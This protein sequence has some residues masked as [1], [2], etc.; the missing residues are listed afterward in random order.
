MKKQFIDTGAVKKQHP[1]EKVAA[2]MGAERCKKNEKIFTD[3]DGVIHKMAQERLAN[4]TFPSRVK[5]LSPESERNE[6]KR[7]EYEKDLEIFKA[8]HGLCKD[9]PFC[10]YHG[11]VRCGI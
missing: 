3:R 6:A 11:C 8:K 9:Y 4:T 1:P 10:Q 2:I 7:L 5:N